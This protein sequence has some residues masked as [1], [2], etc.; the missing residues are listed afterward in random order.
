MSRGTRNRRGGISKLAAACL[1]A[2]AALAPTAASADLARNPANASALLSQPIEELSYD[3]ASK[4]LGRAQRGTRALEDW[5]GSNF[6]GVSWGIYRCEK[7]GKGSASVHSEGRALDWHLDAGVPADKRSA[8]NLIEMLIAA[9]RDGNEAALARRM[10]VQG[11]I[12]NCRQWFGYGDSLDKYS[13]CFNRQ[14]KRRKHL[15]RTEAHMDHVHIEL[16]WPGARMR[17]SFWTETRRA[18]ARP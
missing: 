18:P 12:F 9:D 4:C 2:L 6:R 8:M 5:V 16:N 11:I 15:N 14:G 7:W 13:Y 17:T 10:G 1:L 3:S